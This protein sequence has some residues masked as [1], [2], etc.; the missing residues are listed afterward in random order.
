MNCIFTAFKPDSNYFKNINELISSANNISIDQ[1]LK[2]YQNQYN[3][4]K[5]EYEITNALK[6]SYMTLS[7]VN[8]INNEIMKQPKNISS[9]LSRI[10]SEHFMEWLNYYS[11]TKSK[12]LK[13]HFKTNLDYFLTELSNA[14]NLQTSLNDEK[15][16]INDINAYRTIYLKTIQPKQRILKEKT[17]TILEKGFYKILNCNEY[18][19]GKNFLFDTQEIFYALRLCNYKN[20]FIYK[21]SIEMQSYN[22]FN[23][24]MDVEFKCLEGWVILFGFVSTLGEEGIGSSTMIYDTIIP[25]K[26]KSL[27]EIFRN[28]K[29]ILFV[30]PNNDYLL[31]NGSFIELFSG[32]H[33]SDPD[34]ECWKFLKRMVKYLISE[35][36]NDKILFEKDDIFRRYLNQHIQLLMHVFTCLHYLSNKINLEGSKKNVS[37][38][39]KDPILNFLQHILVN[40]LEHPNLQEVNI[41]NFVTCIFYFL[42]FIDSYEI[43]LISEEA[44]VNKALIEG[45][46]ELL[47]RNLE[48]YPI[49]V[50]SLILILKNEYGLY[51][52]YYYKDGRKVIEHL[53]EKLSHSETTNQE[54]I[55][56]IK[57]LIEICQ[58]EKGCMLLKEIGLI[59]ELCKNPRFVENFEEYKEDNRNSTHILWCWVL[60]LYKVFAK[61]LIKIPGDMS[62]ALFFIKTYMKRIERVLIT[63]L[64]LSTD[65]KKS[66]LFTN[67]IRSVN[68]IYFIFV[69]YFFRYQ[70]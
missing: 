33:G 58:H 67:N 14:K 1:Q 24:I 64:I 10:L 8:F 5:M 20:D 65:A 2:T 38:D 42:S 68:F 69:N 13:P 55:A 4:L 26:Q 53:I 61:G 45:L 32:S 12:K 43:N 60:I 18:G 48:S 44:Q 30:N 9:T 16:S 15:V 11:F 39:L 22:L 36:P 17:N 62:S 63:P 56:I 37:W 41:T 52:N 50:Y 51:L 25:N 66:K 21:F 29:E 19:Y 47:K 40:V 46:Y 34:E 57:F 3:R 23:S 31:E 35:L 27:I 28:Q 54:F 7:A 70:I 6:T 59:T 49:I